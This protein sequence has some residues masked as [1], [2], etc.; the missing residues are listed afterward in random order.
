MKFGHLP[1][2]YLQ[3]K[4]FGFEIEGNQ[5]EDEY[6]SRTSVYNISEEDSENRIEMR[7]E[8]IE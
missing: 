4:R 6:D 7:N 3:Y 2:T 8:E 5:T 1:D